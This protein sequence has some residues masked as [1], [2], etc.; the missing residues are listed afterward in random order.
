MFDDIIQKY[1]L[2]FDV[3]TAWLQAIIQ[4]ESSFNAN[5]FRS[6]PAI[7]DASYGL[8]QLLY[9]TAQGLGYTG[10]PNGL[11]DPD[12]N[13]GLGTK[14][15]AQLRDRYGNDIQRI[16]SAYNSGNPDKY[17][18]SSEVANNVKR[19]LANLE[20]F[21]TDNPIVSTSGIGSI[22]VVLLMAYWVHYKK[23]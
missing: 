13:I 12:I 1:A 20:T 7:N 15:I 16:Y 9:K 5:A 23:G 3:P 2:Q 18:T 14:L 22:L 8:M 17:L 11:F 6:E 21:I 10:Q 4:T 19:L